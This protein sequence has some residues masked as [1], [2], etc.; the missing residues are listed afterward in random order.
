M[1]NRDTHDP[2]HLKKVF[3]ES[4][5]VGP[6]VKT[7]T[8][9]TYDNPYKTLT[10]ST[11]NFS[12]PD[13]SALG[14]F[15]YSYGDEYV[16]GRLMDKNKAWF[17]YTAITSRNR[18]PG[19]MEQ[20]GPSTYHC[21]IFPIMKGRDLRIRLWTVGLLQPSDGKLLLPP[22]RVPKAVGYETI[23][24]TIATPEWSA[25][26]VKSGRLVKENDGYSVE[27]DGPVHAVAQRFK[28]GRIYVSGLLNTSRPASVAT[29]EGLLPVAATSC[30]TTSPSI[31]GLKQLKTRMVDPNTLVFFGWAQRNHTLLAS[32]S[33]T[34]VAFEPMLL[35]KGNDTARLWAQQMLAA[36]RWAGGSRQVLAFSM[37]YGVP[38]NATALLAVPNEEMRIYRAKEREFEKKQAEQRRQELE[39]D[40]QRRNWAGKRGQNWNSS[41]GGDPEIR[42]VIPGAKSVQAILP[43]R[44][45]VDLNQDGDTWGGNFEIPADALEGT[46][47]VRIQAKMADGT[48]K[49]QSWTY[50][51]NRTPPVGKAQFL[52]EAGKLILE[53]KSAPGLPEVAAYSATGEKWVLKEVSPGVYRVEIPRNAGAKLT[54]VMKDR[55]GNK[56]ELVC[57][58][59]Q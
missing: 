3:V 11:L 29:R 50:D 12:L 42:V 59:P 6:M 51:V 1:Y 31:S 30:D 8:W 27:L 28:D 34:K 17:I 40:R 19:I 33:G 39:N 25:R 45:V 32:F 43:D 2:F 4:T 21:Q 53:V 37:K 58:L 22:A 23:D 49:E 55:A 9:L 24:G 35:G 38:S 57:S 10:E 16:R 14:G 26:I 15:A 36:G 47:A 52:T 41:G 56:G 18:D 44:R 20:W 13:S 5:V 48:T 7:S 54:V 46:Y